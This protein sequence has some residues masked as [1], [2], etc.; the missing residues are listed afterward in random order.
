LRVAALAFGVLAGLVASLILA[1]G[2]LDVSADLAGTG[3]RQAQAIRFGLLVIGNLGIFGAALAIASPLSGAIFLF[4]GAVAWVG[5]ALLTHHTTD[6]VLI[7][8]PALLLVG[9]V[10]AGIAHFRRRRTADID[11]P[12]IEIIAPERSTRPSDL[13]GRDD[14]DEI[15][16]PSFADASAA[17]A[18]GFDDRSQPRGDE[19][20][21][22]RRQPPPPRTKPA[23][24][25]IEDEYD[26]EP[27]GFSRFALGFSGV[28]SFGLY[29]ALA[30][31]AVLIFWNL[32]NDAP[33]PSAAV[34]EAPV[35]SAPASSEAAAPSSAEAPRLSLPATSSEPPPAALSSEE[36]VRLAQR[37]TA[38]L[39]SAEPS[40]SFGDVL[41]GPDGIPV[42]STETEPEPQ[43]AS[44]EPVVASA[45]APVAADP[46]PAAPDPAIASV[47][48]AGQPMPRLMP[49]GLA[50]LRQT[51]SPGVTAAPTPAPGLS[52]ATGL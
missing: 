27:S 38:A 10:F 47:P 29:A 50:A 49:V 17:Q 2:G 30:G 45:P 19:W 34:A 43:P 36:P 31:A 40:S 46:A 9:A 21:P 42:L 48:A 15:G 1:L 24:R 8:P 33:P 11:E 12:E 35:L 28:L 6:F 4:V 22:R 14:D 13:R 37:E 23:F 41:P 51:P 20:N 44:A 18:R 3:E 32:R 7:T 26:E 16:M 52:N 25:D 5:A 39:S